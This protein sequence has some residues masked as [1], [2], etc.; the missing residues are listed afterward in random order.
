MAPSRLADCPAP[1]VEFGGLIPNEQ[2]RSAAGRWRSLA[3]WRSPEAAT[4][5]PGLAVP[6]G[7]VCP[8][9]AP[10]GRP[11]RCNRR[12]EGLRAKPE[13]GMLSPMRGG[14]RVRFAAVMVVRC[15]R[16]DRV[17]TRSGL[18][19]SGRPCSAAYPGAAFPAAQAPRVVLAAVDRLDSDGRCGRSSRHRRHRIRPST[20]RR[21]LLRR[22]SSGSK[23]TRPRRS[24]KKDGVTLRPGGGTALPW[25]AG[26]GKYPARP[27]AWI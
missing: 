17:R 25:A 1:A 3:P 13:Q 6:R 15:G 7:F 20:C 8:G 24:N 4:L 14:A 16:F 2:P 19:R 11:R 21:P 26:K 12:G 10:N 23:R 22:V 9:A 27:M 5:R 18:P